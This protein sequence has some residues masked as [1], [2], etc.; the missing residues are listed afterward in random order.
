[1]GSGN[2]A[3]ADVILVG[4]APRSGT[5][6]LSALL[7]TS[8]SCQPFL[9]EFHYLAEVVRAWALGVRAFDASTRYFTTERARFDALHFDF[10]DRLL[11]EAR[12]AAG[13]PTML[14]I[15][16]CKLTPLLPVLMRQTRRIRAVVIERDCAGLAVSMQRAFGDTALSDRAVENLISTYNAYYGAAVA[17]SLSHPDR[18][19]IVRYQDLVSGIDLNLADRLGIAGLRPDRLWDRAEFDVVALAAEHPLKSDLWGQQ[20]SHCRLDE[21]TATIPP[22]L[23]ARLHQGTQAVAEQVKQISRI[24]PA[25]EEL[26]RC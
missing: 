3:S 23:T 6:L 1:M 21:G 2:P 18:C 4:G 11:D 25:P 22:N 8:D 13:E 12:R 5:T 17:A 7:S 14:V 19:L 26:E 15:K 16:H 9:P 24:V 20:I 10:V